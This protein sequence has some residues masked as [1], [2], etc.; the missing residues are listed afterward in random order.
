MFAYL[1]KIG[2]ALMVPVAVLPAAAILMGIGYWIDPSG[3]GGDSA[4]AAFLI[5]SGSALIDNMGMLFAIGLAF[6]LS[7]DK[8]GSAALTGLVGWLIVQ[9]LLS[10]DSMSMLS[11]TPVEEVN[12]AF[13]KVN[14]QFIGILTGVVSAEVYNRTYQVELPKALSF[15][16]GRRLSSIVISVVMI[17]V[18]AVLSF[19]WPTIYDALVSF[20][21]FIQGFG[22]VGAG[23]YG[24]FNRLL[25]PTGLHHALNSVF[26]FDVADINDIGN[27]L[28]GDVAKSTADYTVGMYQAGFF[29]VMMFGLPAGAFAIYQQANENQKSR[30]GG[31]L[32]AGAVASFFTGVTEPLEFSFMFVAWPLYFLHAVL[33][34]ISVFIS[35]Q[36]QW[37]AGFGFSAGFVD[38]FLSF[39]NPAA[40]NNLMLLVQGV[41]FA[42]IY[43]VSFTAMIKGLNLNT[44]GRGTNVMDEDDSVEAAGS[45][46]HEAYARRIIE[47]IGEDNIVETDNCTTRLRFT[48]KDSSIVEDQALKSLNAA[49]YLKPSATAIQVIIGPDVQFV[50][51]EIKKQVGR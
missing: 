7:K 12:A 43:Y 13:G 36:M 44:P 24:F 8:H 51:D 23:F 29:P 41:V 17:L 46:S 39:K 37:I 20:G 33:T 9:A 4:I 10:P 22:A 40:I 21:E 6:G 11:G 49:G 45:S 5:T 42:L 3:W 26:W 27:Y 16:S 28:A 31:I 47:A 15:F 50:S 38:Y 30:V 35:A 32:L 48:V 18:A 19:V 2:K 25:I 1:Q 34:G 14:N